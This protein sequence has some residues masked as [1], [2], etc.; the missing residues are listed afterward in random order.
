MTKRLELYDWPKDT[1][2]IAEEMYKIARVLLLEAR[3]LRSQTKLWG[4]AQ[5]N[6][7]AAKL[8]LD[9]IRMGRDVDVFYHRKI[10]RESVERSLEAQAGKPTN[11]GGH[12]FDM[13]CVQGTG[14]DRP[15]FDEK[16]PRTPT[17]R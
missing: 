10:I 4:E 17:E 6:R 15:E 13:M 2:T 11:L 3:W 1:R 7:K 5:M 9:Q 12:L 14:L 16:T 8:I